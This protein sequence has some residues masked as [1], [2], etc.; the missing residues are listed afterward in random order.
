MTAAVMENTVSDRPAEW[1]SRT[2]AAE[3]LGV[4]PKTMAQWAHYK[5]GPRYAR[6][7]RDTRYRI[8]DLDAWV[9]TQFVE[10]G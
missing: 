10:G 2:E 6:F 3:Y 1:L 5:R 8:T 7:G 9:E 4:A